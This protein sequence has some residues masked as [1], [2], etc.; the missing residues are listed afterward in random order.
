M[1]GK[2]LYQSHHVKYLGVYLDECLNWATHVNQAN[3]MFSKIR[4]FVNETTLRSISFAIFNSRYLMHVLF[5]GNPLSH[6]IEFPF[7]REMLYG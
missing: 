1:C 5:G 7:Y 4:Y 2:N 6:L 3:A